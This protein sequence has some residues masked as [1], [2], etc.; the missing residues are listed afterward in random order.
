MHVMLRGSIV[1]LVGAGL[2]AGIYALRPD[3]PIGAATTPTLQPAAPARSASTTTTR[4]I[5]TNS[6]PNAF[7]ARA[8]KPSAADVHEATIHA[9]GV[10]GLDADSLRAEL[11]SEPRSVG[12]GDSYAVRLMRPSGQPMVVAEIVLIVH[13][14]DGT[15]DTIAM[16]ALP[17]AGIYRATVPPLRSVPI[18][19]QV[20]VGSGKYGVKIRVRRWQ[21]A[22]PSIS[23]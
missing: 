8:V 19:L 11:A 14:A 5:A 2:I 20:G 7:V 23:G 9:K 13:R 15:V 1:F 17:E 12:W 18:D 4:P 3:V 21:N 6:A 22:L 16:G 10:K